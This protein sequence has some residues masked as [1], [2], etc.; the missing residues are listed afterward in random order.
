[1]G[2]R[3]YVP[4]IGRFLQDDPIPGG[5][6][7]A[8]T[9]TY[10]DPINTTDPTGAYTYAGPS[11]SRI[12]NMEG[13]AAA[14]AAEQA[15]INAAARAAAEAAAREAEA[16]AGPMFPGEGE[17]SWEE[18]EEYEEGEEEGGYEYAS[19][20]H[21]AKPEG[22]EGHVEEA[23]FY[24]PIG[25][26]ATFS[27]LQSQEGTTNGGVRKNVNHIC[28]VFP[29]C[30]GNHS[31]LSRT[32]RSRPAA[33]ACARQNDC[34]FPEPKNWAPVRYITKKVV[35]AGRIIIETLVLE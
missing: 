5:S 26:G 23:V 30:G 25:E 18:W 24:Q 10:G 28:H 15:A 6:A 20:H 9:Y 16:V 35:Q 34:P 29:G 32:I 27:P 1:M 11:A 31:L 14:A 22:G 12:A 2:A 4:Q 21:G 7:N 17:E 3:S 8:Y 19:Y 33:S 13:R